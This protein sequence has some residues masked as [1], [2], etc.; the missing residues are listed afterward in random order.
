MNDPNRDPLAMDDGGD[1]SC[2]WATKE[3]AFLTMSVSRSGRLAVAWQAGVKTGSATA[4]LH[5][6]VFSIMMAC[7]AERPALEVPEQEPVATVVRRVDLTTGE[8]SV[9]I[10]PH[11]HFDI[12]ANVHAL[13][14]TRAPEAPAEAEHWEFAP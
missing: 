1:V 8:T 13:L 12:E 5:P 6:E 14:Y 7:F 3:G 11:A 2:D 10:E 4:Q 9:R